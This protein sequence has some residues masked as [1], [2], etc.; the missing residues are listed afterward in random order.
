M[1]RQRLTA[2]LGSGRHSDLHPVRPPGQRDSRRVSARRG[3]RTCGQFTQPARQRRPRLRPERDFDRLRAH[4]RIA[5]ILGHVD[6][7]FEFVGSGQHRDRLAGRHDLAC[8][9]EHGDDNRL[10]IRREARVCDLVLRLLELRRQGRQSLAQRRSRR[11]VTVE[12]GAADQLLVAQFLVTLQIVA[13]K[14][15]LGLCGLELGGDRIGSETVV[16]RIELRDRGSWLDAVTDIDMAAQDLAADA[17][18]DPRFVTRLDLA[19]EL[20]RL[21][22][23]SGADFDQPD[24]PRLRGLR[25]WWRTA[26]KHDRHEHDGHAGAV[27]RWPPRRDAR[28]PRRLWVKVA[29]GPVHRGLRSKIEGHGLRD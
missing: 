26:A 2:N 21:D 24:R 1:S 20:Q 11:L 15:E 13:G 27:T 9:G 10:V 22:A 19:R 3:A 12:F 7:D 6:G 18:T 28:R 5:P 4:D 25:R 8:L 17:K 23:R 29:Q 16:G 14:G